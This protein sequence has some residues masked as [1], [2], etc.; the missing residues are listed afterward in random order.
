MR[1]LIQPRLREGDYKRIASRTGFDRSHVRRVINGE[2]NNP[3]GEILSEA[4]N[5]TRHRK[6]AY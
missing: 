6:A 4:R 3:S 1:S 5:L 2:S